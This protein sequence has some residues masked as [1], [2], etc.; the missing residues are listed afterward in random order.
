MLPHWKLLRE[1]VFGGSGEIRTH[2]RVAPSLVFKTSALN[3]S[4]TL[5]YK[6]GQNNTFLKLALLASYS[7]QYYDLSNI[8]LAW[9][10][11]HGLKS[12]SMWKRLLIKDVDKIGLWKA[13]IRERGGLFFLIYYG[14]VLRLSSRVFC[15]LP[16]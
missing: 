7:S 15:R 14:T 8:N 9:I 11:Y 3:R 1:T 5:P 4:A 2:G 16:S 12:Y 10:S 13:A 6:D